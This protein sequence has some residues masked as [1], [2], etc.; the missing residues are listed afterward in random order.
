MAE[1][2]NFI[3]PWICPVGK[4]PKVPLPSWS[5]KEIETIKGRKEVDRVSGMFVTLK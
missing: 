1:K 3:F 5:R 4:N 2:N